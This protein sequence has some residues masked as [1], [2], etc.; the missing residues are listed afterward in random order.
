K[1]G[2]ILCRFFLYLRNSYKEKNITMQNFQFTTDSNSTKLKYMQLVDAVS[3]AIA[4]NDLQEGELL[5]SVNYLIKECAISRDTVFKAYAELKNRGLI[6]SVP[7]RGYFVAQANTKVLLFL[8]TFKAY[9]EVLYASFMKNLPENVGIDLQFHHYNIQ[10]FERTIDESVGKYSAYVVMSFDHPRMP[11][12]MKRL[13][14]EKLLAI[15]WNIH[16]PAEC[17]T[18]YQSFGA[19]LY[20]AL[21]S[22]LDIYSC[23]D[24]FIYIYPEYTD[25]PKVSITMFESFCRDHDIPHRVL[26]NSKELCVEQG[27]LYLSVSDRM[28]SILLD[29]CEAANMELGKDVGVLSY[30]ETPMKKY[31]KNGIS[32]I[33]TDFGE[34]GKM[35]AK[36][37]ETGE[38]VDKC[39]PTTLIRRGSIR[40]P[41]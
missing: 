8:D 39:I 30:N 15:D 18:V 38:A 41:A 21:L 6:V 25:H 34:M 2:T 28:L 12:L 33:T 19:G 16:C 26:K 9:K 35:V 4:N 22:D 5:P 1:S 29:Q 7:N 3:E 37:V 27:K 11:D 36:F 32:V 31:I 14:A 10:T 17:S 23:Y 24:E 20:H 13:P 40:T